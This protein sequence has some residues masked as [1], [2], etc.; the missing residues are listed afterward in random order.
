MC[1]RP[2]GGV[3]QYGG[4][5]SDD[6]PDQRPDTPTEPETDGEATSHG[7][8]PDDGGIARDRADEYYPEGSDDDQVDEDGSFDEFLD[9]EGEPDREPRSFLRPRW[10]TPTLAAG[11]IFGMLLGAA[12]MTTFTWTWSDSPTRGD[13]QSETVMVNLSNAVGNARV[14]LVDVDGETELRIEA[15]D[16]PGAVDTYNQV[17]LVDDPEAL[18]HVVPI[19]VLTEDVAQWPIPAT[20]NLEQLDHVLVTQEVYDG[21]PSPSGQRLWTGDLDVQ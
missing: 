15:A 17:W 1:L 10:T 6:R 14:F 7:D 19:G 13:V 11:V 4:R 21:D 20:A 8:A 2:R 9:E 5:V 3:R 18:T 16:L 12:L